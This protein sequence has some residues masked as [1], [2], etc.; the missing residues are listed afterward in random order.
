MLKRHLMT[1]RYLIV[2]FLDRELVTAMAATAYSGNILPIP[3]LILLPIMPHAPARY[4]APL[5]AAMGVYAINTSFRAAAFLSQ[6]AVESF[7]LRHTHES[8]TKRK[9]F[10]LPGSARPAHTTTSQRDYFE[11]WYGSRRDVGNNTVGDGYNYRGRDGIQI[12]GKDNYNKI[13]QGL[14][15]HLT[16]KPSMLEDDPRTGM[17]I[18]AFF[19][20]R[21]KH[22]NTVADSVDPDDAS[23]IEH[24]NSR[25]TRT[26][27]GGHNAL[28]ER[29][30]YYRTALNTLSVA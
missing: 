23:S 28:A 26:I 5:N 8:W 10:H 25:L 11:Y 20:A 17:E 12:T 2:S 7:E 4:F 3:F 19:F 9:G 6:L 13:G 1:S 30:D 27:N 29:L 21:L 18:A 16:S 15:L 14:D 24:V 22:L